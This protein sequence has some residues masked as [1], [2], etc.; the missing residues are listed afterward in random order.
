[1]DE[2]GNQTAIT[3]PVLFIEHPGSGSSAEQKGILQGKNGRILKDSKLKSELRKDSINNR[4]IKS[5]VR[6]SCG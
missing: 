3:K 6:D 1:M 2:A 5:G 4:E